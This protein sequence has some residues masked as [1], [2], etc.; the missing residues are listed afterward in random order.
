MLR[1]LAFGVLL[2]NAAFFGWAQGWF[3]PVWPR[4]LASEHEPARLK[5]QFRPELVT[6]TR[7]PPAASDEQP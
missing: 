4:P 7:A 1:L 6:V 5:A 2:A 3:E